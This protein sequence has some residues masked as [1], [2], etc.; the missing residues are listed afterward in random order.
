MDRSSKHT[1]NNLNKIAY[2]NGMW[3]AG[4]Y[5]GTILTSKDGI[6]WTKQASSPTD[7]L[8]KIIYDKGIWVIIGRHKAILTSN[9]G[10]SWRKQLGRLSN[11]FEYA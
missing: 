8:I 7:H 10:I 9:D 2:G 1:T 3:I 6:S 4:S 11:I 5:S